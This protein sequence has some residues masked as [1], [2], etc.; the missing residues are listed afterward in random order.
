[1]FKWNRKNQKGFLNVSEMVVVGA[2]AVTIMVIAWP[3]IQNARQSARVTHMAHILF[4]IQT[5]M[6]DINREQNPNEYPP[7]EIVA[8]SLPTWAA[9]TNLQDVNELLEILRQYCRTFQA[10]DFTP[11]AL[12]TCTYTR[13]SGNGGGTTP[14]G[15]VP[16]G[17]VDPHGDGGIVTGGNTG[18]SFQL[19]LIRENDLSYCVSKINT[20]YKQNAQPPSNL[21]ANECV[22][23]DVCGVNATEVRYVHP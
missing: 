10:I 14:P 2:I 9:P 11:D 18:P 1:M 17:G 4:R 20:G 19:Q 23:F 8:T 3:G 7:D 22:D 12:F 6:N 15:D 13:T 5:L 21:I 16:P